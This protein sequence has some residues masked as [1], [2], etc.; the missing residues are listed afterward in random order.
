[1]KCVDVEKLLDDLADGALP[2]NRA[3][4]VENHIASCQAC[5]AAE[6]SLKALLAQARTLEPSL[7]PPSDLWLGIARRIEAEGARGPSADKNTTVP[8]RG[9]RRRLLPYL[10]AAAAL[11]M[12][13]IGSLR[14][15]A[16]AGSGNGGRAAFEYRPRAVPASFKRSPALAETQAAFEAAR[17]E[18]Y[19][20]LRSRRGSLSK[21]TLKVIEKNLRI[22]D[23]AAAEI[24]AALE[25]DPGNEELSSFLV[26]TYESEIR[27]LR[28]AALQPGGI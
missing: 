4:E 8:I 28:Q 23:D 7:E 13:I 21:E 3:A 1:M 6:L 18:L 5:Q 19:A 10:A 22:I 2:A 9:F 20:A 12:G 14:I 24:E 27:M 17:A 25:K 15:P 11:I 16:L 26:M